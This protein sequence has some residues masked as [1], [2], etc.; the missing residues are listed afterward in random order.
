MSDRTDILVNVVAGSTPTDKKGLIYTCNCGWIDLGHMSSPQE[1]RIEIGATN[2]WRQI[3][4]E[5]GE[6]RDD[7]FIIKYAQGVETDLT[8]YELPFF[9]D[10]LA[11]KT[12][13]LFSEV[14]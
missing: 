7:G 9:K 10:K 2:L 5:I 14:E 3:N 11:D 12:Y 6:K 1:P 8:Y 13:I 4:E